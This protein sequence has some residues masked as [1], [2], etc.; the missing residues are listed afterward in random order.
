LVASNITIWGGVSN[1]GAV[2]AGATGMIGIP[3]VLLGSGV[4]TMVARH[5]ITAEFD[6]RALALP[7]PLAPGET[8]TG[9]LFFPVTPGPTRLF[10]LL[11][12]T[13]GNGQDLVLDLAPLAGLHLPP[14]NPAP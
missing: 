11:K 7:L 3:L 12:D 1:A 9:S 6:R 13:A 8:R 2:T 14:A 4:R 10:L 5:A